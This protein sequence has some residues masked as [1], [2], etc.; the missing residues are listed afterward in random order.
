MKPS[1]AARFEAKAQFTVEKLLT[2]A[3]IGILAVILIGA[4]YWLGV[5]TPYKW[6]QEKTCGGFLAFTCTHKVTERWTTVTLVNRI[7]AALELVSASCSF[8]AC[9]CSAYGKLAPASTSPQEKTAT[10]T[11]RHSRPA[12][13]GQAFP[14]MTVYVTYTNLVD[15]LHY[16]DKGTLT[17]IVE[18]EELT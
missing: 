6:A 16:T 15:N 13:P 2:Y 14:R 7:G 12:P 1:E 4:F 17:G 5:F 8:P 9:T 18:L 10:I 11:C 3:W